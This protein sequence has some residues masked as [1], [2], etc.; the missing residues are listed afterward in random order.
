MSILKKM[1]IVE[2]IPQ[3][4]SG[5][6]ERFVV[7][8]CNDLSKQHDVMLIVFFDGGENSFYASEIC[9]RVKVV[10]MHK[11]PGVDFMLPFRLRRVIHSFHPDVVHSHLRAI[12]YVSISALTSRIVHCHT[13]H[14]AA[15]KEA[16]GFFSRIVRRLLFRSKRVQPITISAESHRSFVDFYGIDAPMIFNGRDVPS[17]I[18]PAEKAVNDIAQWRTTDHT[19]IIINLARIMREKR[20]GLIARVCRRLNDEGY[21]FTMIF[22]GR[23]TDKNVMK[24]IEAANCPRA[25]WVGTRTN[26]LDY[27]SLADAYCLLSEYEGM[28]ISL[29]EALGTYAVPVCTPVG[30]I[31]DVVSDGNNGFLA[32]DISEEACY[33][34]LK[35]F[36]DISD[37]RLAE[38][39]QAA[40]A[41]YEPFSMK[42]CAA[43][44]ASLFSSLQR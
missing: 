34:A 24:E 38:M 31:V 19:R 23:D 25:F 12:N 5:G 10:S 28:P 44:Y 14:N 39:K 9:D 36:L 11:K 27:L 33:K 26:P 35:R 8:L 13:V 37:G 43:G 6:G 3:L 21:D 2:V 42:A 32:S 30:G 22:M 7:D 29:I 16:G 15:E 4:S 1:R 40:R 17:E 18:T 41:A 20:Q